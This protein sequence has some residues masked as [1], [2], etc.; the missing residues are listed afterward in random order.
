MN[1]QIQELH[2]AADLDNLAAIADFVIRCCERW[3]IDSRAAFRIQIAI[4]DKVKR[5]TTIS[6]ESLPTIEVIRGIAAAGR[7]AGNLPPGPAMTPA[8]R[9]DAAPVVG[10]DHRL[11]TPS[12]PGAARPPRR[13]PCGEPP[14]SSRWPW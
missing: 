1:T 13:R 10:R 9:T 4:D 12:H 14:C 8:A 5:E 11:T 3:N 7:T 6:L 2:I